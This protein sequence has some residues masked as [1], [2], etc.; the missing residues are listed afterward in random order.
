[1]KK[2]LT[3]L[4]MLLVAMTTGAKA[5][6]YKLWVGETQVTDANKGDILGD[7]TMTYDPATNTMTLDGTSITSHGNEDYAIC[8]YAESGPVPGN[9]EVNKSV[10]W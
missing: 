2:R 9:I 3:T 10:S 4:V 8:N 5:D 1:M 6:T 7:G